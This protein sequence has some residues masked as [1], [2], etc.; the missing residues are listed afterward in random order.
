MRKFVQIGHFLVDAVLDRVVVRPVGAQG[1]QASGD[2]SAYDMHSSGGGAR[3]EGV[4]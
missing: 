3:P 2:G 4:V 1:E